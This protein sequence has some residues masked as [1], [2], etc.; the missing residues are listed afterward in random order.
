[1]SVLAAMEGALKSAPTLQAP[2]PAAVLRATSSAVGGFATTLTS[3]LVRRTIASRAARTLLA[4]THAHVGT[5]SLSTVTD[6]L[7]MVC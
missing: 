7:V 3:A 2:S 5:G 1:M 4:P 6:N